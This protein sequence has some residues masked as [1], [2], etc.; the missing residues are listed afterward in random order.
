MNAPWGLFRIASG[1]GRGS[2]IRTT[3]RPAARR[4]RRYVANVRWYESV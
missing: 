4:Y 2:S 3:A 1:P